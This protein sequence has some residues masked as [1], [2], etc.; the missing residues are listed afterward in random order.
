[1]S[2]SSSAL[3]VPNCESLTFNA[4]PI[5]TYPLLSPLPQIYELFDFI[6]HP[7]QH[8]LSDGLSQYLGLEVMCQIGVGECRMQGG[9]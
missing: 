7:S 1:M 4:F 6:S 5:I 3:S 9:F 2:L 8:H